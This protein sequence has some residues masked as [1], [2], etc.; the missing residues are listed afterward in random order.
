MHRRDIVTRRFSLVNAEL[1]RAN[2]RSL[3]S[4][5]VRPAIGR[6]RPTSAGRRDL[7]AQ[8]LTSKLTAPD[9]RDPWLPATGQELSLQ[10]AWPKSGWPQ[11][12][13][14]RRCAKLLHG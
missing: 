6:A 13:V 8:Q 2:D 4:T 1:P 3:A 9:T 12:G 7:P 5:L 14:V 11:L 10:A